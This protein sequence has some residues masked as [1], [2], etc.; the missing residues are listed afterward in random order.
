MSTLYFKVEIANKDC[1]IIS[2]GIGGKIINIKTKIG[3]LHL[4]I[5]STQD[6]LISFANKGAQI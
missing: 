6:F 4:E 2:E 3:V 5:L 1:F